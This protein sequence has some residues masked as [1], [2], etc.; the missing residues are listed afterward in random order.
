MK[1]ENSTDLQKPSVRQ[2]FISTIKNVT[3]EKKKA[4]KL[5]WIS[6]CQQ[7]EQ[8]GGKRRGESKRIYRASQNIIINVFLES[9]LSES[10]PSL[11]V[12]VYL[13]SLGCSPTLGWSLGLLWGSSGSALVLLLCVLASNAHSH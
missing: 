12:T 1:K 11:G 6:Q 9:L 3:E 4:Q 13:T 2:K 5:N 8:K 7:L 10:F